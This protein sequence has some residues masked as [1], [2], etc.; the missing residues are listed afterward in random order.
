MAPDFW[1]I[2]LRFAEVTAQCV[3]ASSLAALVLLEL[4]G[5]P[6]RRHRSSR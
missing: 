1:P 6:P 3:T 4:W 5:R 2:L